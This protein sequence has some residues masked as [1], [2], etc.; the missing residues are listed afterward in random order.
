MT[1]I[2]TILIGFY[3]IIVAL[4]SF[5]VVYACIGAAL[6]LSGPHRS[7]IG[8]G[9]DAAESKP[10]LVIV[11]ILLGLLATL[12]I[13]CTTYW[14]KNIKQNWLKVSLLPLSILGVFIYISLLLWK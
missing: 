1:E 8:F 10:G 14:W 9:G 2:K 5:L 6:N 11:A 13:I 3:R 12:L 7:G 4:I